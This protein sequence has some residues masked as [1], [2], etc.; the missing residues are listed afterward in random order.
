MNEADL[1]F[2]IAFAHVETK[3]RLAARV[4][5]PRQD[6][7]Q[8]G[9]QAPVWFAAF[10]IDRDGAVTRRRAGGADWLQALLMAVEGVRRQIPEGEENLWLTPD[11]VP[12]W[13]VLPRRVPMD[14]GYA[15]YRHIC[16]MIAAAEADIPA[17][18]F[19]DG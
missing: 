18:R 15:F 8:P 16:S 14:W 11:G 10:E 6:E 13:A 17:G 2:E 19:R 9:D 4:Y 12:S 1:A 5:L 3:S 7:A